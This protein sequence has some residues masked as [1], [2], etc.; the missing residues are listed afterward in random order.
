MSQSALIEFRPILVY[1]RVVRRH[2]TELTE[3][4]GPEG[5]GILH[6]CIS[7]VD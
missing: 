7:R 5:G 2:E 1:L 3:T 4:Q 6:L